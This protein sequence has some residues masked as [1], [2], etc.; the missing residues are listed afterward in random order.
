M[1][2]IQDDRW[3]DDRQRWRVSRGYVSRRD[4]KRRDA[5]VGDGVD[6]E[7]ATDRLKAPS[8]LKSPSRVRRTRV[9]EE[10]GAERSSAG[11]AS[12]PPTASP[13]RSARV[14]YARYRL[15]VLLSPHRTRVP[16]YVTRLCVY[17]RISFPGTRESDGRLSSSWS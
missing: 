8:L 4:A 16:L 9:F 6:S 7:Q 15:R 10:S 17:S 12:E 11:Y 3:H 5:T 14:S 13:L 2:R 1:S